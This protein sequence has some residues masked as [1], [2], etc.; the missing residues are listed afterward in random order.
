MT[1][2]PPISKDV[3]E[4]KFKLKCRLK[5]FSHLKVENP[6]NLL[7][8]ASKYGIIFS[9]TP[10]GVQCIRT[11][12]I[13]SLDSDHGHS[14]NISAYPKRTL[15]LG[16]QPSH[17]SVSADNELLAVALIPSDCAVLF[18]YSIASFGGAE[19]I[20]KC[21][22]RLSN[23]PG[24]T[25]SDLQWNPGMAN[26][27]AVVMADGSAAVIEFKD[28]SFVIVGSIPQNS[29]ASCLCW[30]PKGK[31]VVIGAKN[32][33][34]TQYKPELKAVKTYPPPQLQGAAGFSV[35]SVHWLSN[36]QFIAAYRSFSDPSARANLMV[37][38]VPKNSPTTFVNYEDFCFGSNTSRPEHYFIHQPAWNMLIVG[39]TNS[40]DANIL[41]VEGEQW[42]QWMLDD[43]GRAELPLTNDHQ[44]VYNIGM[45]FDIS[46]TQPVPIGENISV[47][48]MPLL[49]MLSHD[50]VL[51]Y[52]QAINVL[53]GAA[54][55]CQPPQQF[56][57]SSGLH[58][59]SLPEAG[60]ALSPH[61]EKE[62]QKVPDAK[63]L[64]LQVVQAVQ[65]SIPSS[66]SAP[67]SIEKPIGQT[68]LTQSQPAQPFNINF[69]IGQQTFGQ[70]L[71]FNQPSLATVASQPSALPISK[72][73]LT[74]QGQT[75]M[76]QSL[77]GLNFA[78]PVS[79]NSPQSTFGSAVGFSQQSMW[80]TES[81]QKTAPITS[82][83]SSPALQN[84]AAD[85]TQQSSYS[86]TQSIFNTQQSSSVPLT[87]QQANFQQQQTST[88]E[89]TSVSQ[90][91]SVPI[92]NQ[93]PLN[94][95]QSNEVNKSPQLQSQSSTNSLPVSSGTVQASTLQPEPSKP[96]PPSEVVEESDEKKLMKEMEVC[97][98]LLQNF[99]IEM[100][101]KQA[102]IKFISSQ[103][104]CNIFESKLKDLI[105]QD[106]EKLKK[107]EEELKATG[108]PDQ[109]DVTALGNSILEIFG[110]YEKIKA[111][112]RMAKN[113]GYIELM[114]SQDLDPITKNY[115]S[116]ID[117]YV[118]YVESQIKQAKA[119]LSSMW[120]NIGSPN[121]EVPVMEVIYQ[122]LVAQMSVLAAKK[123][124]VDSCE[125]KMKKIS[126]NRGIRNSRRC[127]GDLELSTL[128]ERLLDTRIS[129][130]DLPKDK[131]IRDT[132]FNYIMLSKK[133]AKKNLNEDKVSALHQWHKN[134]KVIT[135]KVS[136]KSAIVVNGDISKDE[137]FYRVI[138]P[139]KQST[140]YLH[141]TPKKAISSI[142][143]K[144]LF[145]LTSNMSNGHL[146]TSQA[147]IT[148][149][150]EAE[151]NDIENQ[152]PQGSQV[153]SEVSKASESNYS[154]LLDSHMKNNL[155][156]SIAKVLDGNK[157]NGIQNSA[158]ISVDLT[159]PGSSSQPNTLSP[160]PGALVKEQFQLLHF[161]KG[162]H[163]K[164]KLKLRKMLFLHLG[165]L[166]LLYL[167]KYMSLHQTFL[168]VLKPH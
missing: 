105:I 96:A 8:A 66:V 18:I 155:A 11:D 22:V 59:F 20:K 5:V 41:G 78:Q 149:A 12:N 91:T 108:T 90:I 21:E 126:K 103:T 67:Q 148:V 166:K 19:V 136:K 123:T 130:T 46:P 164:L 120:D 82:K 61:G 56:P 47:D 109:V 117:R 121:F 58:L 135:T 144:S 141:A 89:S 131:S 145:T 51:C 53:Q 33:S 32:G 113:P 79:Q 95:V 168:P 107:Y 104:E 127:I 45:C 44:D 1:E 16:V 134:H 72:F 17:L 76:G 9:G 111:K 14:K 140:P 43:G 125:A 10:N 55:L 63:E 38:N 119:K 36:F 115:L 26:V 4:F 49:V 153:H 40:M 80:S 156:S 52:F 118:Y 15:Q 31:Q 69:N 98:A 24:V 122:S 6:I 37:V 23:T 57:D 70:S 39:T 68:A 137:T 77:S 100:E 81:N 154:P 162:C 161:S 27:L 112:E 163:L 99:S 92:T 86:P 110:W 157:I 143:R 25:V 133:M 142:P 64:G 88:Q 13:L 42:V 48:P 116:N 83:Q 87:T 54:K 138:S 93:S 152:N 139:N 60:D 128:A 62:E 2:N 167:V 114:E 71:N 151:E 28:N 3:K 94:L 132:S 7:A 124:I 75:T 73:S 101:Q 29:H 102:V 129:D 147:N 50:G 159:S 158:N 97:Q 34:L 165:V 84:L 65:S 146:E 160:L 30:S 106:I 150:D 74:S 35:V 85:Q